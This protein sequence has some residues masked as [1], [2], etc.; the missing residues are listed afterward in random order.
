MFERWVLGWM[1]CFFVM[2]AVQ[3]MFTACLHLFY[4]HSIVLPV[5]YRE[6]LDTR[7]VWLYLS[8][9]HF[10]HAYGCMPSTYAVLY[11]YN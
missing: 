1:Y 11:A 6:S 3:H 8:R 10:L 7:F 2:P 5:A 4:I 9:V